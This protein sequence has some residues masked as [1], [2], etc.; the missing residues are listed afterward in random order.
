MMTN[1]PF[2]E[3]RAVNT[4]QVA[5]VT[6][7]L[8]TFWSVLDLQMFNTTFPKAKII[9]H[10]HLVAKILNQPFSLHY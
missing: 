7:R 5:S 2:S 3:F 9:L 1:E 10:Y 6:S 4:V 8:A